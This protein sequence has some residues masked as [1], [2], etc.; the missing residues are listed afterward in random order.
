MEFADTNMNDII[1][2]ML[3]DDLIC[4]DDIKKLF[5]DIQ[6]TDKL[7][8]AKAEEKIIQPEKLAGS[9]NLIIENSL[10]T[11]Q[12]H[13]AF[14]ESLYYKMETEILPMDISKFSI[15]L[16][17]NINGNT[18]EC[19]IDTGASIN[20]ISSEIV[21]KAELWYCV[22][23]K[24]KTN[25]VGVGSIKT[26]GFI[27]YLDVEIAGS[28]YPLSATVADLHS[29]TQMILGISFLSYYQVTLDFKNRKVSINGK[30]THFKICQK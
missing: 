21:K 20:I 27:P 7:I 5:D 18:I 13:D 10:L 23:K 29:E 2:S 15:R 6:P 17:V 28:K 11:E 9:E 24:I 19:L 16:P 22:D 14:I 26:H 1:A 8:K 30:P 3:Y 12:E 4:D 25:L